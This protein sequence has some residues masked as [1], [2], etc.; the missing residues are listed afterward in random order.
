MESQSL[1][2]TGPAFFGT[3]LNWCLLGALTVQ[4]YVFH[5]S[6]P[7][8]RRWIRT[9]VC[10]LFIVD[11]AQTAFATHWAWSVLISRQGNEV[12]FAAYTW[13]A[14]TTPITSAITSLTVQLFFAWRIWM[15]KGCSKVNLCASVAIALVSLVQGLSAIVNGIHFFF[16]RSLADTPRFIPAVIV[17]L[18]GS[19]LCDF[20]IAATLTITLLHARVTSTSRRTESLCTSLMLH[21]IETGTPTFVVAC[22]ELIL[23]LLMP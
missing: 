4:I 9:L 7:N 14:C 17:W 8:E 16:V 23:F 13:S 18:A 19:C 11:L 5:T 21:A 22:A 2:F 3:I 1:F 20:L 10:G 12:A 6:F 15:L